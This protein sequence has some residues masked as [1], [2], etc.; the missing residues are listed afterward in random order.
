MLF[1]VAIILYVV[2]FFV[3]VNEL[4]K[5]MLKHDLSLCPALPNSKLYGV[6]DLISSFYINRIFEYAIRVHY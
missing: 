3:H 5:F 2:V 4:T 6:K 1:A